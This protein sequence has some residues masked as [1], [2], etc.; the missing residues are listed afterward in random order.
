MQS[1][2]DEPELS[3]CRLTG[4]DDALGTLRGSV[5]DTYVYGLS[6]VRVLTLTQEPRGILGCPA[7]I[8][9]P[10]SRIPLA[11]DPPFALEE[12]KRAIRYPSNIGPERERSGSDSMG[13]SLGLLCCATMVIRTYPAAWAQG[14]PH[15]FTW[16]RSRFVRGL[17]RRGCHRQ[18]PYRH[19]D[20]TLHRYLF[21]RRSTLMWIGMIGERSPGCNP[22]R[23]FT[24]SQC[25]RAEGKYFE[26][27]NRR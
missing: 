14:R 26:V 5:H 10:V 24:R 9:S 20:S 19:R 22:I 18:D 4:I 21:C 3:G 1:R 13:R 15:W 17:L 7:T 16:D 27:Q 25:S 23:R 6:V 8:S 12:K 2:L 11:V